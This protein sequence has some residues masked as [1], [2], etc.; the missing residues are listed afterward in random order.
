MKTNTAHDDN[1][2][3][4]IVYSMTSNNGLYGAGIYKG[5]TMIDYIE[6]VTSELLHNWLIRSDYIK[7]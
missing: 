4:T 2:V 7:E 6:A 1:N 5:D 3:Y